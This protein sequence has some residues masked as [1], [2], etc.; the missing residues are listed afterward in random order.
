MVQIT[1]TIQEY[2]EVTLFKTENSFNFENKSQII[3]FSTFYVTH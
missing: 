2:V 3:Y 1:T